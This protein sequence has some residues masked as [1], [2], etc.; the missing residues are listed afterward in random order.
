MVE[1]GAAR[2]LAHPAAGEHSESGAGKR[3]DAQATFH[4]Y[5]LQAPV[6]SRMFASLLVAATSVII[7]KPASIVVDISIVRG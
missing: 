7:T 1:R 3:A 2:E 5:C 6:Y 4:T